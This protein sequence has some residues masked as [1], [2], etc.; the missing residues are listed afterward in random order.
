MLDSLS[1]LRGKF[2]VS[3]SFFSDA[4]KYQPV[5]NSVPYADLSHDYVVTC[6]GKT[7]FI[8][9]A[10]NMLTEHKD[11]ATPRAFFA[12]ITDG[13]HSSPGRVGVV[14]LTEELNKWRMRGYSAAYFGARQEAERTGFVI[15]FGEKHSV[16]W[17]PTEEG[18][19]NLFKCLTGLIR[20]YRV[21][22]ISTAARS[23]SV[24][25]PERELL[26]PTEEELMKHIK[27]LED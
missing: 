3:L 8:Q 12:A 1:D 23:A 11:V 27:A 24:G 16:T 9:S 10:Y 17:T 2:F 18:V 6:E 25:R 26:T 15:G 14:T 20:R 19:A 7:S 22:G 5:W 13:V 21:S 4:D